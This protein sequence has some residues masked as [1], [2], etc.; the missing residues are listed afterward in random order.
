MGISQTIF[1]VPDDALRTLEG[2]R[3]NVLSWAGGRGYSSA[4]LSSYWRWLAEMMTN[5]RPVDQLPFAALTTGDLRFF[6]DHDG[7][8]ALLSPGVAELAAFTSTLGESD[9]RAHVERRRDAAVV[10]FAGHPDGARFIPTESLMRQETAEYTFYLGK[11]KE[12]AQ[13]AQRD[14]AGLLF[15]YWEDL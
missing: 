14:G 3:G 5:G 9:V 1:V 13:E 7:A 11:V 15:C 8:H 2:E 4:Y 10:K 12:I 6:N